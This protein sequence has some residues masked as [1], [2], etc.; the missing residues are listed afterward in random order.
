[1]DSDRDGQLHVQLGGCAL[2]L[3]VGSSIIWSNNVVWVT[4]IACT[5]LVLCSVRNSSLS[6]AVSWMYFLK[7]SGVKPNISNLTKQFVYILEEA[8]G[9]IYTVNGILSQNSDIWLIR[10]FST[11]HS[12]NTDMDVFLCTTNPYPLFYFLLNTL[13]LPCI[14]NAIQDFREAYTFCAIIF[15][16]SMTFNS[17]K[18][19]LSSLILT[20]SAIWFCFSHQ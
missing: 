11:Y 17:L 13:P 20:F 15:F 3:A 9:I 1:M 6:L 4:Q 12:W 19:F 7:L 5:A 14:A 8:L 2:V 10:I 18:K 16:M